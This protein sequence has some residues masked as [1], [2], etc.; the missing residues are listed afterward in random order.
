MVSKAG[1][2]SFSLRRHRAAR[3]RPPPLP[4]PRR[5]R[6]P[7]EPPSLSLSLS[8]SSQQPKA[9]AGVSR[10]H[11]P[12]L[13]HLSLLLPSPYLGHWGAVRGQ[14]RRASLL[15]MALLSPCPSSSSSSSSSIS[16]RRLL[17][18]PSPQPPTL[19]S[20]PSPP[21]PLLGGWPA[22]TSRPRPRAWVLS[23]PVLPLPLPLTAWAAPFGPRAAGEK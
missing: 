13:A 4:F 8:F 5:H 23:G 21:S 6:R 1:Q 18:F 11:L 17:P 16:S 9:R 12:L 20:P 3:Y 15:A 14:G 19:H 2:A 7:R 10:P 22:P